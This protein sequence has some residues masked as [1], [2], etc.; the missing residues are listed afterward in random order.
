MKDFCRV[1]KS[2]LFF[3]FS[4][5]T[6]PS[7]CASHPGP[8]PIWI[9][10]SL[11]KVKVKP[12]SSWMSEFLSKLRPDLP[13]I[14]RDWL[15]LCLKTCCLRLH[16]LEAS[17]QNTLSL[18]SHFPSSSSP[19]LHLRHDGW[20][21]YAVWPSSS[22]LHLLLQSPHAAPQRPTPQPARAAPL[23]QG[24]SHKPGHTHLHQDSD[25]DPNQQ[26]Q[27]IKCMLH[28]ARMTRRKTISSIHIFSLIPVHK[29]C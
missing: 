17:S 3:F 20:G 26:S 24:N 21:V 28:N 11:S 6:N 1:S 27:I 18:W 14:H 10:V 2:R 22:G 8:T 15:L 4:C 7:A 25:Q 29:G 19:P 5:T 23:Q 12:Q 16:A 9:N 13:T